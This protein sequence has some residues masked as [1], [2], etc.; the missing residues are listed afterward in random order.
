MSRPTIPE[1]FTL[2]VVLSRFGEPASDQEIQTFLFETCGLHER[3]ASF[4]VMAKARV[5][6]PDAHPVFKLLKAM[7]PYFSF[8]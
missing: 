3:D 8:R 7:R 2:K 1:Q 6:G 4:K 5:D